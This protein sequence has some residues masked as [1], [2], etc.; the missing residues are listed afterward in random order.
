MFGRD[1]FILELVCY[2]EGEVEDFPE[3]R[4]GHRLGRGAS[5]LRETAD[6][7][8]RLGLDR[9]GVQPELVEDGRDD[10]AVLTQQSHEQV[11]RGQ[12]RVPGTARQVL[13]FGDCFLSFQCKFIKVH[14]LPRTSKT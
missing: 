7:G 14:I 12:F 6:G 3:E 5:D 13:G 10:A 9:A 1:V 2:G 4:R 8:R 11:L